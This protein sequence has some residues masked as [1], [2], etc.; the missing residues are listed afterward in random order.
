MLR[1]PTPIVAPLV[2]FPLFFVTRYSEDETDVPITWEKFKAL[3]CQS[4]DKFKAF[5]DTIWSTIR[6]NS[7]H[8]LEKVMDWAAH[9]EQL[10]T[11]FQEFD[12]DV[13]ILEPVW[14]RLFCNS[15]RPSMRAQAKQ[16]SHW[17]DIW[18]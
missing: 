14:I 8:Q 12:A 9:L 5:V 17:K 11:V 2:I 16:N 18:E 13:L 3:L 7:E 6:K 15:L 4:L 10:Q 1:S